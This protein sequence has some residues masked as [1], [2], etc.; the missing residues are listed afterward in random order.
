MT[1]EVFDSTWFHL[2][3]STESSP[4]TGIKINLDGTKF[5]EEQSTFRFTD[6]TASK[7][8]NLSNLVVSSGVKDEENPENSTYKTYDLTPN[9]AN[10]ILNYEITLLEYQDKLAI[11]ATTEDS[12]ASMKIKVPK[13]DESGELVYEAD[14]TTITCEEKEITSGTALEVMLNQLG[15]PDTL[16]TIT[17]TAEDGRTTKEYTLTIKRPYATI[18]GSIQ[19]GADIRES[20]QESYGIYTKFLADA[21]IYQSNLFNW[22]GIVPG[23]TTY[24]ELDELT[25]ET[26]VITNPD[27]GEYNIKVIPGT[28]DLQLDRRGFLDTVIKNITVTSGDEIDLG[29]KI[30]IPGDVDRDRNGC[31]NRLCRSE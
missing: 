13:R 5:Y 31:I 21:I 1:E 15:E 12:K 28:Y 19:L 23:D 6:Q 4:A 24:D 3:S 2:V 26:K 22:D 14:G 25:P 17:V 11:T 18:K 20:M 30:L 27:T 16:L 8:A 7:N 29:N 9:F 10:D